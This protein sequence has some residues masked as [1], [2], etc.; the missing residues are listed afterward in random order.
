MQMANKPVNSL[1]F[2]VQM[3]DDLAPA[4]EKCILSYEVL[5]LIV[6]KKLVPCSVHF[7]KRFYILKNI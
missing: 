6:A 2:A 7:E 4:S 5:S 3:S 1:Q